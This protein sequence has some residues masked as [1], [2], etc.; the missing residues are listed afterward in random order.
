MNRNKIQI[1]EEKQLLN[2]GVIEN[3]LMVAGFIPVI[4]EIFDII[5]IIRYIYKKEY[6]YA[7]LML[8]ALIPTVGDFIIK[9]FIKLIR[10]VS[11][12]GKVVL[13]NSDDIV[14]LAKKTPE[15]GKEYVKIEKYLNSPYIGKLIKQIERIPRWGEKWSK[16]MKYSMYQNKIAVTEIK[17]IPSLFKTVG[18]E[19]S[20]GG[21][22]STGYKKFFQEKALAKYVA[23]RGMKP[24]NWVSNWWNVV[25]AGRKDR[26]NL[27]KKFIIA[28]G[29]LQYFGLPSFE[30][31]EQKVE[32]DEGFR[33]QLANDPN[34]T[35]V[36][37]GTMSEEEIN[38]INKI[39][40]KPEISGGVSKFATAMGL[41][42][43]KKIAQSLV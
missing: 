41:N 35:N 6:L 4:G 32:N 30:S 19:I 2:E 42:L 20:A 14:N 38:Q 34:F 29:I 16:G 43:V 9:P 18:K 25:R 10:G 8:I 15:I 5:L 26:R 36:V 33:N 39:S 1:I 7:G 17:G 31:F 40:Q 3:I 12:T 27:I 28:N 23:D 22:F 24:S 21:K 11:G 13:K 37:E